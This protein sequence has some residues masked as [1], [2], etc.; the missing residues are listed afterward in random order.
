MNSPLLP[1]ALAVLALAAARATTPLTVTSIPEDSAFEILDVANVRVV[2]GRTPAVVMKPP[3]GRY[4]VVFHRLGCPP[5]R[6]TVDPAKSTGDVMANFTLLEQ[7]RELSE[8]KRQATGLIEQ[9]QTLSHKVGPALLDDLG[10]L[11]HQRQNAR[12]LAMLN[13]Y[14]ITVNGLKGGLKNRPPPPT[15]KLAAPTPTPA[16]AP[17]GSAFPVTQEAVAEAEAYPVLEWNE[18]TVEEWVA[19]VGHLRAEVEGLRAMRHQ[20]QEV[21]DRYQRIMSEVLELSASDADVRKLVQKWEI[22]RVGP[23]MPAPK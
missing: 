2:S 23:A 3:A 15:P 14:G 10:R 9:V 6:V 22:R 19:K 20:A 8:E 16:P 1:A 12:V 13:K 11:V 21:Q 4:R 5:L 18:E 17:V 7:W